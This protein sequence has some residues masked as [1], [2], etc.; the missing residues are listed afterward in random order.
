M[1][2]WERVGGESVV[3]G[4]AGRGVASDHRPDIRLPI[5]PMVP[6]FDQVKAWLTLLGRRNNSSESAVT[7]EREHKGKSCGFGKGFEFRILWFYEDSYSKDLA[8]RTP[9]L[10]KGTGN[11]LTGKWIAAVCDNCSI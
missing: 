7:S 9:T 5:R 11:Q 10:C 8:C 4:G 2:L 1:A 6:P 3:I